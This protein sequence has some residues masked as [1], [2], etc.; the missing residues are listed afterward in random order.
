MITCEI[1]QK[2]VW[3]R[4]PYS[5]THD[6]CKECGILEM[7]KA[8]ILEVKYLARKRFRDGFSDNPYGEPRRTQDPLRRAKALTY[9]EEIDALVKERLCPYCG[10]FIRGDTDW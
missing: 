3:E 8:T 10:Q 7:A 6:W 5:E 1:C 4:S 2:K 9:D